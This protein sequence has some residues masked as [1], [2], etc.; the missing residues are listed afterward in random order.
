MAASQGRA[1]SAPIEGRKVIPRKKEIK[2]NKKYLNDVIQRLLSSTTNPVLSSLRNRGKLPLMKTRR[3]TTSLL[4]TYV[5]PKVR[6][7]G[8]RAYEVTLAVA[9]S[10][11]R[12]VSTR[13]TARAA[14]R[15]ARA[16]VGVVK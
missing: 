10:G 9:D 3:P 8:S 6:L 11:A 16:K 13:K 7:D 2:K 12:V 4:R 15:A 14:I 1:S 5:K